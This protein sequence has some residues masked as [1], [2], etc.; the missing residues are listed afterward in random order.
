[1]KARAALLAVCA[2]WPLAARATWIDAAARKPLAPAA[3]NST[4]S[5]NLFSRETGFASAAGQ[6]CAADGVCGFQPSAAWLLG[7]Q[8]RV[9]SRAVEQTL[10]AR[11]ALDH[12]SSAWLAAPWDARKAGLA[13]LVGVTTLYVDGLH[14]RTELAG[15]RVS[16]ALASGRRLRCEGARLATFELGPAKG[17]LTVSAGWGRAAPAFGLRYALRY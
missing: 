7:A 11:Y 17:P 13:A 3:A 14:A 12:W 10:R 8:A 15:W 2:L 5:D 1:M 16:V 4:F 9:V 6:G